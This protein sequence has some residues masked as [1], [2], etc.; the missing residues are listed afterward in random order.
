MKKVL[1]FLMLGIVMF[2][3]KNKTE[4]GRFELEG[5]VKNVP[6]QQVYL[7]QLF[8][9]EQNSSLPVLTAPVGISMEQ[10]P[11][12]SDAS[13]SLSLFHLGSMDWRPNHEGVKWFLDDIWK[14]I[15]DKFPSL[16]LFLAGKKFPAEI[17]ARKEPGVICEGE[18][19]DAH[20]FMLG[21]QIMVVPLKSGGGM[22]VKIIQGMALGKTV[23]STSIGAE[24]IDYTN[25]KNI[26]IANTSA[27]FLSAVENCIG[28][29][30]FC[31]QIGKEARQ[32][33]IEKYSNDMVGK[34]A[35]SFLEGVIV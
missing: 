10:Y 8:F 34:Q 29:K 35:V 12:Q 17:T 6:D 30:L 1:S 25:N 20:A 18:V 22:R 15:H 16:K 7:E 21:K 31:F 4:E 28:D 14:N 26:L 5:N 33:A 23:I 9:T 27:E 13:Q 32:L 24:G 19:N 2:S 11:D 3:C